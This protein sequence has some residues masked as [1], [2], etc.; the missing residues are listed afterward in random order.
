M[1]A[2]YYT[3][4]FD[5]DCYCTSSLIQQSTGGYTACDSDTLCQ[6]LYNQSLILIP[7][8]VYLVVK[9]QQIPIL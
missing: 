3:N 8:V 6:F 2:L 5:L 1:P 4:T 9:K 7:N